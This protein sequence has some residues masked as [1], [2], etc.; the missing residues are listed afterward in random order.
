MNDTASGSGPK[1]QRDSAAALVRIRRIGA[2][3]LAAAAI[4]IFFGLAPKGAVTAGD[5]AYVMAGDSINQKS[6]DS[7]PQQTVVNGWT[8]RD[9]LELVA[10]QHVADSDAR[11]AGLLVIGVLALCLGLATSQTD[12]PSADTSTADSD[13][14]P[15]PYDL[16]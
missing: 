13:P 9:L 6:A 7:A 14:L 5:V 11:P 3:L 12:R 8:A 2:A 15:A 1:A 4:G 10:R 16:P